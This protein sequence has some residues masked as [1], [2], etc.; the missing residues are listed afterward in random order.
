MENIKIIKK[1]KM[2]CSICEE[3]HEVDLIEEEIEICVK[4]EKLKHKE[5]KYRCNKYSE[6]NVF[7]TEELWNE[8]LVNSLDTYRKEKKLLTSKEIKDIRNKYKLTQIE[9]A[10]LLGVEKNY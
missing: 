8:N 10:Q 2:F 5:R 7:E 1:E 6:E 9:M 3:E 4:G